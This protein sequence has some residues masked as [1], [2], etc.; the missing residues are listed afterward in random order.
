[1]EA[2]VIKG[3]TV[4]AKACRVKTYGL[5]LYLNAEDYL[6]F[7]FYSFKIH[8]YERRI[9]ELKLTIDELQNDKIKLIDEVSIFININ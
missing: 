6:F 5:N 2:S 8:H 3:R 7:N 4:E 9:Q 1:M